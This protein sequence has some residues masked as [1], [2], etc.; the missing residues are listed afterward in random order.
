MVGVKQAIITMVKA[1]K[2]LK[3]GMGRNQHI[4]TILKTLRWL[5]R[6]KVKGYFKISPRL[7]IL[8]GLLEEARQQAQAQGGDHFMRYKQEF[9]P[10]DYDHP[11]LWI[12]RC[13]RL[14][15]LARIPR[16]EIMNVLC[17]NFTGKVGIWFES[18]LN[19]LRVGFQWVAFVGAV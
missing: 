17:V 2:H 11:R 8:I 16:D 9:P 3:G 15:M 4:K 19:G 13:E 18:Y 5:Q 12:M 6:M 7:S 10:F 14:F 1:A